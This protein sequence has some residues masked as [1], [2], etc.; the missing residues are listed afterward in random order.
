MSQFTW[1]LLQQRMQRV[2][3]TYVAIAIGLALTV[4]AAAVRLNYT[5]PIQARAAEIRQD[6]AARDK[7]V[8]AGRMD[9]LPR[10]LPNDASWSHQFY[11]HFPKKENIPNLLRVIYRTAEGQGLLLAEGSYQLVLL[12]DTRLAAYQISLPV[13]G[14]YAQVRQ[15]VAQ[16]LHALP[17]VAVDELHFARDAITNAQLEAKIRLTLYLRVNDVTN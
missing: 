4:S 15:F 1:F 8:V 6:L 9:R 13:T 11:R 14:S 3:G 16:L 5:L 2:T 17:T 10:D 7:P 12:K